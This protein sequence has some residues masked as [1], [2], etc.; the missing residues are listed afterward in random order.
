MNKKHAKIIVYVLE[1]SDASR[2]YGRVVYS[3]AHYKE[4]HITVGVAL[5]I[6]LYPYRGGHLQRV[7]SLNN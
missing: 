2:W 6:K 5:Q 4:L 1:I 7:K 3:M